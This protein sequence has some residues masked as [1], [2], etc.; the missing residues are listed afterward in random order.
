[1]VHLSKLHLIGGGIK[2]IRQNYFKFVDLCLIPVT[3][4]DVYIESPYKRELYE[5]LVKNKKHVRIP[6]KQSI[7]ILKIY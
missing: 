7:L 5:L 3:Q 4:N 6:F 1:M 2:N